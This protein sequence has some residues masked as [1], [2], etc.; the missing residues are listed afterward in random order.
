MALLLIS[1]PFVPAVTGL[2]SRATRYSY[3][4]TLPREITGQFVSTARGSVKLYSWRDPQGRY[5][6]DT[7]RVHA[8]DVRSLMF[9]AAAVDTPAAYKLFESGSGRSV[10][11]S[12][13]ARSARSLALAPEHPLR[14]GRYMLITS[15]EGMFGGRDYSY[16]TVVPPGAA[17]SAIA[18]PS[19]RAA[20][21]VFDSLLPVAAALVAAAFAAMLMRS[22]AQRRGG[23]KALWGLG[24]A[25]FA[26]AAAC[27]ALAQSSGWSAALFRG[28]YLC[29][30][31][32]TVAYLGAGS[33]W[34]YL[35]P[36]ARDVMVG[37]LAL[38]TVAAALT[39][40][41]APVH[42]GD[43]TA[44]ASGR[45]PP[46]GAIGGGA[47]AWAIALNSFGT[48]WLIGGALRSVLRRQRVRQSL[49]IGGG[50]LVLAAA[51]SMSRTGDYSLMYLGEL[52]GI[53]AMF[54]GFVLPQRAA[55]P[56]RPLLGEGGG[57]A[58]T[59]PAGAGSG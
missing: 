35:R 11:L 48:L 52:V 51:T 28:Y 17:A 47:A 32:L 36:R 9:R 34:L 46:N 39:V 37:A 45:P 24:F 42:A 54:Y 19:D 3:E 57:R 40:G 1:L 18:G 49:W 50:A 10:P 44:T 58:W 2:G 59:R 26:V 27:E 31:V 23:Q 43:L 16:L 29:G 15:H 4:T 21:A 53:T 12:V 22:L 38:A 6:A 33:A 7:L 41:L 5:P 55:R 25:F 20:P 30:G 8:A 13:R 56:V 14:P